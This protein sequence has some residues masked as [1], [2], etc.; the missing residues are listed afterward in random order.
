MQ[1]YFSVLFSVCI[2]SGIVSAL[3]PSES[4]KKYLEYLCALCVICCMVIPISRILPADR[5]IFDILGDSLSSG[6]DY[7]AIYNE[8]WAASDERR[9]CDALAEGLAARLGISADKLRVELNVSRTDGGRVL[10]KVRVYITDISALAA[11]PELIGAY[12]RESAGVE[13]EIIYDI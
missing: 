12:I 7:E 8:Y 11:D 1:E 6:Q 5:G 10:E 4:T 2:V 9:A 13:C 3:T